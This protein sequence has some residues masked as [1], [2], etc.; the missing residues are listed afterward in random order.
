MGLPAEAQIHLPILQTAL[1]GLKVV[2]C[3]VGNRQDANEALAL[4]AMG[5]VSLPQRDV[6]LRLTEQC[7]RQAKLRYE[8]VALDQ[9]NDAYA[10]LKSGSVLGRIVLDLGGEK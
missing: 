9:I 6:K 3:F 1:K 10:R 7:L 2:G 5:R 8:V 4:H